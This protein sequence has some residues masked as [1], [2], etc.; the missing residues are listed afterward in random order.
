MKF[1]TKLYLGFGFIL[2]LFIALLFNLMMMMSQLNQNINNTV[3]NYEYS[4]LANTIQNSVYINSREARGLIANPPEEL[5]KSFQDRKDKSLEDA[6]IAIKSL[7]K[8]DNRKASQELADE[9]LTLLDSLRKIEA[10][11]KR[12]ENDGEKQKAMELFW[13]DS[14]NII[15]AMV[16]ASDDLHSIQEK[17]VE[18]ELKRSSDTYDL[19]VKLI[20]TY[21]I[22]GFFTFI[23]LM[24]WI[25]GGITKN[26]NHVTS[27]M[28][29]V[30]FGSAEK[31]PRI[32]VKSKDE[33]GAISVAFNEM[34][35]AIENHT[36]KEKELKHSAE[37]QSWLQSRIA[38]IA[39]M[40]SGIDQ[41]EQLAEKFITKLAPMVGASFGVFY[42]KELREDEESLEKLASYAYSNNRI[43]KQSFHNGEGI[44]G[45]CALENKMIHIKEVPNDYIKISSGIGESVPKHI[46]TIP[47]S[48][49]GEVLAVIELASFHP[50]TNLEQTLLKEVSSNVGI[51]IKSILRHNQVEMLLLESQ[52][53][54][55]EL[56]T[57]S[58]ELNLQQEEL[59]TV[60]EQL[61][62]QYEQSEYKT[63]ELE[64]IK[65]MLEEKANQ[66]SLSSKYKSEFFANMSHELRT[67]LNSLLISAE[68][69]EKNLTSKQ[70]KYA[71]T[72]HSSGND[73]LPLINDILDLAKAEA[74]K[75]DVHYEK[76]QLD[77]I[78]TFV[79][80]QFTHIAQQKGIEFTIELQSNVPIFIWTD[81]HRLQQILKN[82]LLNAFKF[83][84]QGE[85]YFLIG[86]EKKIV[87]SDGAVEK[88]TDHVVTFSVKDTGEGISKANLPAI[89]EVF[90]QADGTTSRKY[91]GTGLGLS[92]SKEI[93]ELLEGKIE[94]KSSKGKGSIF[95]LYIPSIETRKTKG[96]YHALKE[97][98]AGDSSVESYIVPAKTEIE[99]GYYE[100]FEEHIDSKV[101]LKGKKVLVVDD[102][103]RNV[104]V[105]TTALEDYGIE[106]LFA[107][108]GRE[109]IDQ[110][111]EDPA[112]DLILMDMMMPEMDGLEAIKEIRKIEEFKQIPIIVLT[113][114]AMKDDGRQ[115]IE[116]GASDYMSKPVNLE[117]LYSLMWVWLYPAIK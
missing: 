89:F 6:E 87:I 83:T 96:A 56:Q 113:A 102:D 60:N 78:R 31:L 9:I 90:N 107:E 39:T 112:I 23:F 32:E 8:I 109:G 35:E 42:I 45:Q 17:S 26:L 65:K 19:A 97:V 86:S 4:K 7:L 47:A 38:E 75:M 85:V 20:S 106:V 105:I 13:F 98:A 77:E 27:V 25:L 82:L 50:F 84:E 73:L 55:E 66:L 21:A 40:Y 48:Y 16:V 1:K 54:T 94:V 64:K 11:I 81:R 53:L 91:G 34:A 22:I 63:K 103:I 59:R 18:T 69:S 116:A 33:I 95:T 117:Q 14:W 76:V 41:L 3:K 44:V 88:Q 111:L 28:T 100:A 43:G 10:D 57:Q 79:E 52:A 49:E 115:C 51:N 36:R 74:G 29:G 114:K 24:I 71:K 70:M 58:E 62:Q 12:L 37:E 30:I 99:R 15:N 5:R 104:F 110:L 68:N 72:I 101:L 2:A 61:E 67:P 108:N 46:L 80:E 93:A 92:I